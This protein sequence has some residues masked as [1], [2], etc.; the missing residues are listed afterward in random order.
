MNSIDDVRKK[1]AELGQLINAPMNKLY[2]FE[3]NEEGYHLELHGDEYHYIL[4]ERGQE[5]DRFVTKIFD[6]LLYKIFEH[7]TSSMAFSYEFDNRVLNQD[8]RRI[9]FTKKIELMSA[10]NE[11][12]RKKIEQEIA[13]ILQNSPY[14]DLSCARAEL[15]GVLMRKGMSSDQAYEEACKKFP[16][17]E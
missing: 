15:C 16:L 9:A 10:I 11:S 7:I 5:L 2:V 3:N 4:S 1:V 8:S 17:P 6:D 13:K 14:D 12:W